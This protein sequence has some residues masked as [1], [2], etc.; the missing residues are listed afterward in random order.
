MQPFTFRLESVLTI[1]KR[2]E[3]AALANLQ[4]QQA[5]TATARRRVTTLEEH[6][7]AARISGAAPSTVADPQV[8]PAWHRNWIAHITMT[9]EAAR[10]EVRRC[11][12]NEEAARLVWQK[13]RRD[14]RVIERLRERA[15]R[16]HAHDARRDEMKVMDELAVQGAFRKEGLTW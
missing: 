6:R 1:W 16:R 9:L 7:H 2:R 14:R 11:A 5:T 13:A 4:R 8:D 10:D 12:A 3:D 15:L